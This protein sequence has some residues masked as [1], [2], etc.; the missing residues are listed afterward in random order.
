MVE[1]LFPLFCG[2]HV[3]AQVFLVALLTDEV[4]QS[5]GTKETI[6]TFLADLHVAF[7]RSCFVF[8]FALGHRLNLVF[9]GVSDNRHLPRL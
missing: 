7:H 8:L 3:H 1:G 2:F 4:L 6:E 9:P 5:F